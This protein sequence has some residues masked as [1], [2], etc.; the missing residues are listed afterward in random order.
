MNGRGARFR[1]AANQR[2][3][4][5]IDV[6]VGLVIGIF[7]LWALSTFFGQN[8][9]TY[10]YQ[11]AQANQQQH[12]RI[13]SFLLGSV[14]RQAGYAPMNA[15]RL[16]DTAALFPAAGVFAAGQVVSGTQGTHNVTVN[17]VTGAQAY[18]DDTIAIRYIGDANVSRCNGA[19]PA[20]GALATDQVETDGIT[21]SCTADGVTMPLFGT[22]NVPLTQQ[23]RVLGLAINYGVDVDA[24]ESIDR[25]VRASAVTDWSQV[26]VA[27]IEVHFQAGTRAP[28][29]NSFA[30]AFENMLGV[31]VI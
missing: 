7:I 29:A 28:Q 15:T 31:D 21:F 22:A 8:K 11:Q 1:Y 2:G 6:L 24:D 16:L 4:G 20:A 10:A 23:L 25:F 12:E 30:I 3:V 5:L 17:G 18:P 13:M 26:K 27:E 14:L 19:A 9:R